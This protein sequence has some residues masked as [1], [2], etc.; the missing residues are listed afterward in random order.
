MLNLEKSWIK[1]RFPSKFVRK[2]VANDPGALGFRDALQTSLN[3]IESI[4]RFGVY[5]RKSVIS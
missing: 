1:K 2:L 3:G 5:I 4:L